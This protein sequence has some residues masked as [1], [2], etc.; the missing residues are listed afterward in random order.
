MTTSDPGYDQDSEPT[1]TAP[2]GERPDERPPLP[3]DPRMAAHPDPEAEEG[4]A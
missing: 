1:M 4:S 2:Q 3:D